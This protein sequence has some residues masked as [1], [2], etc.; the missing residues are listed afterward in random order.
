M[1]CSAKTINDWNLVANIC[2][3]SYSAVVVLSWLAYKQPSLPKSTHAFNSA[4]Y[5]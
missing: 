5:N 4:F 1:D 2:G 3:Y